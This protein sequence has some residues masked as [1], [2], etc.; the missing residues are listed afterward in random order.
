MPTVWYPGIWMFH[1]QGL[2]R[3]QLQNPDARR[4]LRPDNNSSI[5]K[6]EDEG[7]LGLCVQP[8]LLGEA[9]YR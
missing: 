2:A 8:D 6:A 3:T 7:S 1:S 5:K 4:D 9:A